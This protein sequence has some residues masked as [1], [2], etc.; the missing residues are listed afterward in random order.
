MVK[1][2]VKPMS[3]ENAIKYHFTGLLLYLLISSNACFYAWRLSKK[4]QK[5][6]DADDFDEE[7]LS[8]MERR[9]Y[10]NW[11]VLDDH[12]KKRMLI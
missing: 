5:L 11:I 8:K 10:L 1:P 7:K 2:F 6:M 3:P 4:Q 12:F 9:M